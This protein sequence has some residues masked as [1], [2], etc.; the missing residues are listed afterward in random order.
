MVTQNRIAYL[1]ADPLPPSEDRHRFELPETKAFKRNVRNWTQKFAEIGITIRYNEWKGTNW[2][3][4]HVITRF[5]VHGFHH[6]FCRKLAFLQTI[7]VS[8]SDA[9]EVVINTMPLNTL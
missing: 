7:H 3:N 4:R 8:T 9:L 5:A 1:I 6:T 2:L